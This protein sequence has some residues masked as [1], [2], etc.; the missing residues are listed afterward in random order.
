MRAILALLTCLLAT[1]C[2]AQDAEKLLADEQ[3][4][5]RGAAAA[6]ASAVVQIETFGGLE[7]VGREIISDG[8]T[9]GTIVHKD[10]WIISSLYS[11]RQQPSSILVA[12]PDGTRAAARIAA[13]D[14]SRELVLLKVEAK[15]ELPI[16]LPCPAE[17][18]S[19]GQWVIGLGRTFDREAVSQSVGIISALDRAYGKAVQTDAK[20]SPVNYG[21]PLVDLRGSTVGILAPISPGAILEG[22]S[23]QLY[24]S[25]IGFAVPLVDILKRLPEMQ[26]GKDIRSGKLGIVVTDQNELAGPV[27]VA[28]A[29]PGSPAAKAGLKPG[30]TIIQ[31]GG[32][33]VEL[34]A[35]LRHALGPSDAGTDFNF[36]V[37][38]KGQAVELKCTLVDQVPTYRP[39]YLGVEVENLAGGG[40]RIAKVLPK[41]PAAEA[42]LEKDMQIIQAGEIEIKDA[43]GLRQHLSIAELDQPLPLKIYKNAEDAAT[44]KST[45]L[46]IKVAT[47]PSDLDS[48]AA[49]SA[50]RTKAGEAERKIEDIELKLGD[51]PNKAWA[52]C[53]EPQSKPDDVAKEELGLLI[54]LPEPGDVDRNK[55]REVWLP[56]LREGW[57]VAVVQ[58]GNKARWSSEEIELVERVRETVGQKREIDLG[59]T[60]VGGQGVGGR[61]ALVAAR[62]AKGKIN[63]VLTLGTPLENAKLQRENSPSDSMH[64]MLVGVQESYS[65]LLKQLRES[66]YPAHGLPA[67]ELAPNKWE[68]VPV[69]GIVNWLLTVGR[70]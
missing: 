17:D 54:L 55:M 53:P 62:V 1:T 40:V 20:V 35:H 32:R 70:I 26:S 56:L 63:G 25:G 27:K 41:S 18:V 31:A 3:A 50:K 66:G 33:K 51:F 5:F 60:V 47:W 10:G 9:T 16:A 38:R 52:W 12:L 44:K 28:G 6:A 39:R 13:R 24:D 8:P 48:N 11:F 68:A 2:Q 42:K 59:R 37:R 7:R 58:S 21:G 67:P 15:S 69:E 43:N 45:D 49:G 4:A 19:V 14:H 34:L 64:F 61:L 23:S 57:C 46:V 36:T 29:A 65:D 22:D 30:D